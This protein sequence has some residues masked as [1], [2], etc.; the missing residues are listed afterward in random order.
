MLISAG[1]TST[2]SSP[3]SLSKQGQVTSLWTM[4]P[5]STACR[6]PSESVTSWVCAWPPSRSSASKTV[7]SW[8]RESRY[9]AVSP[10]TPAPIT[11]TD[12]RRSSAAVPYSWGAEPMAAAEPLAREP[13]MATFV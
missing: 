8:V 11:A 9:A 5:L 4:N 3:K 6:R 13:M 2:S 7:T 10:E 12:G 1:R